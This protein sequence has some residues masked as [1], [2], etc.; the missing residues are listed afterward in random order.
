MLWVLEVV[1][2]YI[3]TVAFSSSVTS[4]SLNLVSTIEELLERESSG[5]GLESWEYDC[6]DPSC[7]PR[8][9]LY[10]QMLALT[11]LTNG[12]CSVGIVCLQTQA[13][14]LSYQTVNF[15]FVGDSTINIGRDQWLVTPL[16]RW[17]TE[18]LLNRPVCDE[19]LLEPD[20]IWIIHLCLQVFECSTEQ[21]WEITT[22]WWP[23]CYCFTCKEIEN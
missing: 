1:D 18:N 17:D 15:I 8:G 11:S 21:N 22:I 3:A 12:S 6:K 5:S 2:F 7:W 19:L 9:T 23:C 20:I 13:T 16:W 14:E 10:P 4:S